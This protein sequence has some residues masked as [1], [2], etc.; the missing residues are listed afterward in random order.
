M[1][2]L[3]KSYTHSFVNNWCFVTLGSYGATRCGAE[4][5][6]AGE[7]AEAK[8]VADAD[9][10]ARRRR[11]HHVRG[12]GVEQLLHR[13]FALR[14]DAPVFSEEGKVLEGSHNLVRGPLTSATSSGV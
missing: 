2:L 14:R 10:D 6:D 4:D 8:C 12:G 5:G 1:R 9:V 7:F 3:L 13:A 11:L